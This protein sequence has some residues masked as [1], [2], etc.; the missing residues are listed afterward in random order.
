MFKWIQKEKGKQKKNIPNFFLLSISV[1]KKNI[2]GVD[3]CVINAGL[4]SGGR[5]SPEEEE[6]EEEE[7]DSASERLRSQVEQWREM[8]EVNV[9]AACLCARLAL[10]H[11]RQK[12]EGLIVFINR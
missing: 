3:L 10:G 11:M 6:A 4:T 12:E 9:V 7:D 2:G 1:C 8:S 5:L